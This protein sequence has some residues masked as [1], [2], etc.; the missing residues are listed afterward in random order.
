MGLVVN[1]VALWNSRYL[2]A[3]VDQLRAEGV[4]VK[5]EDAARL[6]PLGHAHLNVLGRYSISSSAQAEGLRQLGEIPD[7][8]ALP[9]DGLEEEG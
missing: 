1:A 8:P 2:S 5:D 4:P 9:D 7:I 6:S 3:A